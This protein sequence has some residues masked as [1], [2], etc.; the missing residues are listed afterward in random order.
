MDDIQSSFIYC[1]P[2]EFFLLLGMIAN[3]RAITETDD[4]LSRDHLHLV[5]DA[6]SK[7]SSFLLRETET[8]FRRAGPNPIL[9]CDYL[10]YVWNAYP[11]AETIPDIIERIEHGD[12]RSVLATWLATTIDSEDV[13]SLSKILWNSSDRDPF[14]RAGAYVARHWSGQHRSL[15]IEHLEH[16]VETQHRFVFILKQFYADIYRLTEENLS[17]LGRQLA[18]RFERAYLANPSQFLSTTMKLDENKFRGALVVHASPLIG[19]W[20]HVVLRDPQKAGEPNWVILGSEVIDDIE[21]LHQSEDLDWF[22]RLFSDKTRMEILRRLSQKPWYGAELAQSL[23]VSP[24]A[25]SYHMVFFFQLDLVSME[26]KGRRYYYSLNR[27]RLEDLWARGKAILLGE[28]MGF[29]E[30]GQ[31]DR[32]RDR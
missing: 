29:T 17:Q 7:M 15:I 14:A 11:E 22:A 8:F 16:A 5:T 26:K 27:E 32:H 1:G 13:T 23:H 6:R 28:G 24:A 19:K 31:D 20:A 10:S 12:P 3:Y 4:L 25:I 21:T 30:L 9:Y 18:E 2:V